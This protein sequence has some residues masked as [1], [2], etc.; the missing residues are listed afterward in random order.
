[1]LVWQ[2][3]AEDAHRYYHGTYVQ[4]PPLHP[5]AFFS[6]NVGSGSITFTNKILNI[7]KTYSF[8]SQPVKDG[9]DPNLGG[10]VLD[11]VLPNK[12]VYQNKNYAFL[13]ARQPQKQYFRGMHEQNTQFWRLSAH[14]GWEYV[15]QYWKELDKYAEKEEYRS[16][17]LIA[18]DPEEKDSWALSP[19]FAVSSSGTLCAFNQTIG[20]VN[21]NKKSVL[22]NPLFVNEMQTLFPNFRVVNLRGD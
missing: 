19:Y 2:S 15:D 8:K 4:Y 10:F 5:T 1:M 22:V 9:Q 11:Y 16:T 12:K 21:W 20:F 3:N 14:K 7:F 18:K 6:V 13:V 17:D